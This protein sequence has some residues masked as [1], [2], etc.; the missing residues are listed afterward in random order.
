MKRDLQ[1]K[2]EQLRQLSEELHNRKNELLGA[3]TIDFIRT[4]NEITKTLYAIENLQAT[5]QERAEYMLQQ[6]EETMQKLR[7]ETIRVVE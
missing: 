6:K 1:K 5:L 7:R 4:F 2:L 3:D